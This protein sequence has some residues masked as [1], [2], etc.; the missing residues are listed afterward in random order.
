MISAIEGFLAQAGLTITAFFGIVTI[1]VGVL[2]GL[3]AFSI[4]KGKSMLGYRYV[5]GFTIFSLLSC[6]SKLFMSVNLFSIAKITAYILV[7][8]ILVMSA[9]RA[10]F[11]KQDK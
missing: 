9:S 1:V 5:I 4:W 10:Y 6:S 2:Q 11:R 7:I 8:I 3:A